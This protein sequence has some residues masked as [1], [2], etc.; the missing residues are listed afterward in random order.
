MTKISREKVLRVAFS[1]FKNLVDSAPK[2]IEL[3]VEA[4]IIRIID[5]V[6]KTNIK[7]ADLEEDITFVG[8]VVEK[9]MKIFTSFEKY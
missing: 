4:G 9:N 6:M 2:T 7:D 8:S 3:M 5:V 1:T